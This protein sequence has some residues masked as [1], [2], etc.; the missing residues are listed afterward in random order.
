MTGYLWHGKP[1]LERINAQI[2]AE[3]EA[4]I[5]AGYRFRGSM[6]PP[7]GT[8][9]RAQRERRLRGKVCPACREAAA[10]AKIRRNK[11]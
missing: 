4:M 9:A 10:K 7:H 2:M 3:R 8:E 11:S 6:I 5:Q 1:D